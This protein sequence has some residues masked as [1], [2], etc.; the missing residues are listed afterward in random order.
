MAAL[1]RLLSPL[2]PL[3]LAPALV[4]APLGG[5]CPEQPSLQNWSGAGFTPCPCFVTG[6]EVGAVLEVDPAEY[7]IEILRVGFA[8]GS[9][10][11]ST[12]DSLEAAVKIYPAGMPD[13]GVAQFSLPGPVL[14]DGGLLNEFDI[15][16]IPG[17][18][19]IDSGP[20]TVALE[21]ANTSNTD[22]FAP[23]PGYDTD[24]CNFGKNVIY[25]I[26]G[27]WTDACSAGVPGDWVIYAIYRSVNCGGP[28][29]VGTPVCF[30]DG[31]LSFCPC[32]NDAAPGSGA[33]CLNSTG[34]GAVL[35]GSGS[36]VVANDDLV[37]DVVQARAG[38]PGLFLQGTTTISTPFKDGILCVGNPT[39]RLEVAFTDALGNA[40]STASIVTEGVVSVGQIRTYQYW[41]RDPG[42]VSP[43]GSG[44]NFTNAV[45]VIWQ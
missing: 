11:G 6:E 8:W 17:N 28:Q 3:V 33:G 20:F 44:S 26:P 27:G 29:V 13:P 41:Y 35:S 23:G 9:L 45:R 2:A 12:P 25:A 16:A 42:G 22:I 1:A 39:E 14:S 40:T 43:C 10:L 7:P 24:G 5:G 31:S 32:G 30:G 4:A 15:S 37:L 19:I 38:V 21:L 36:D 18:K 34:L